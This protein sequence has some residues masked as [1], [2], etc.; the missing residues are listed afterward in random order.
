MRIRRRSRSHPVPLT[1]FSPPLP[2]SPL[3]LLILLPIFAA[4]AIACG[5]PARPAALV[6]A[7]ANVGLV[8]GLLLMFQ[9]HQTTPQFAA[10]RI[11]LQSPHIAYAVG[12]DGMSL[13]LVILTAIVTLCAVG[14]APP[15]GVS[16]KVWYSSTLLIAAGALGAFLATDLF[17]LYAF[18]EMALIPTF[19]MIGMY[20]H[21]GRENRLHAAWKITIYLGVGSLVLLA[22]LAWLVLSASPAGGITFDI[23]TLTAG[24]Q[25]LDDKLQASIFLILLIGFGI[26]VSLFPFHS[27]AAPAY[28]AAPTP[29]AMMHAGVLKKFGLYGLLRIALPM[30]P[31]GAAS[32]W[33]QNLLLWLLLGNILIIGL[34]TI[35]QKG[36]DHVLGH[37]SVMH[38]G[39]IFLGL[40]CGN[41][42]GYNGALLLMFAHGI[43]IALLFAL[44]GHLRAETGTLEMSRYGGLAK[45]APLFGLLFG[46]AAM[47][48][49]GLPGFAN[50]SAEIMVFLGGFKGSAGHIGPVQLTTILAL[51][52]VVI[53]AVYMLRAYKTVFMGPQGELPLTDPPSLTLGQKL[54]LF[55]L[56][57]TLLVIGFCPQLLLHY[58]QPV[59]DLLPRH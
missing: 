41:S 16:E 12:L 19:L 4:V 27:W 7:V 45:R 18:H 58:A 54:P 50:F 46:L 38:M 10:S 13:V 35:A 8:I 24:A 40:A 25:Q 42:I 48:S 1:T 3:D 17:F 31:S 23:A 21:G 11:V 2:L 22:G 20:G 47:A 49:L 15:A 29:T 59:L 32:L 55:L 52:G 6:A 53:S 5:L 36:L 56:T 39:Y 30:L 34:V 44:A 14:I 57:T 33:I 43:S 51:W 26:L 37:S 9:A 28:A